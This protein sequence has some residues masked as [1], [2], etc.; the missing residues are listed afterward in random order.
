M[1]VVFEGEQRFKIRIN[2]D[3]KIR[4]G[5]KEK[6]RQPKLVNE[7]TMRSRHEKEEG[8]T[9]CESHENRR[10]QGVDHPGRGMRR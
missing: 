10:P 3:K 5:R 1:S 8:G 4:K 9:L 2:Q 6:P 7:S